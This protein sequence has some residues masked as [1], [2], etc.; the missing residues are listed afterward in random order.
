MSDPRIVMLPA[1]SDAARVAAADG[2]GFHLWTRT[3]RFR[4]V[5]DLPLREYVYAGLADS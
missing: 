5:G 2:S 1:D 4:S 3:G